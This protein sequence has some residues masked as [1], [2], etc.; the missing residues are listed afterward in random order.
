M[1]YI[2]IKQNKFLASYLKKRG[3]ASEEI[4]TYLKLTQ[5]QQQWQQLANS[6]AGFETLSSEKQQFVAET[7]LT[8]EYYGKLVAD[9]YD[10]FSRNM[11]GTSVEKEILLLYAAVS[12]VAN[13]RLGSK[14]QHIVGIA[15]ALCEMV[16]YVNEPTTQ[17]ELILYLDSSDEFESGYFNYN[18][19]S[20]AMEFIGKK[21]AE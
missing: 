18:V 19:D 11:S 2:E 15:V 8:E 3:I 5:T 6:I 10:F 9:A 14:Y 16:E 4:E 17:R 1:T 21:L 7:C 12:A 13:A 20:Y